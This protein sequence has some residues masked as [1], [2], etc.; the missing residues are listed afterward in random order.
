MTN[1]VEL[2]YV[3]AIEAKDAMRL[4]DGRNTYAIFKSPFGNIFS[5]VGPFKHERFHLA[6]GLVVGKL[7]ERP[8]HKGRFDY[9]REKD[10]NPPAC[11]NSTTY[12]TKVEDENV[13]TH[14]V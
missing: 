2:Y 1:R 8:K 11:P 7:I 4:D 9:A 10:I 14:L 12:P 6:D 5:T 13:F 3:G